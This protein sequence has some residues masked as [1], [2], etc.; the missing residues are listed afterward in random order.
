MSA[1]EERVA[2][3]ARTSLYSH[4]RRLRRAEANGRPPQ[5]GHL[6]PGLL[7][8]RSSRPWRESVA[9]VH[10]ILAPLLTAADTERAAD[11]ADRALGRLPITHRAALAAVARLPLD[12]EESAHALGRRLVRTGTNVPAVSAGL[13]LLIRLGR[14]DDIPVLTTIGLLYPCTV[15]AVQALDRLHPA[16]AALLR[17]TAHNGPPPARK[18]TAALAAPDDAAVHAALLSVRPGSRSV[19]PS[20]ARRI[21][22]AVGL[23]G[24]LHQHPVDP[25]L[26]AQAGRLLAR[27]TGPGEQH[28]EILGYPD[29][30]PALEAIVRR[31]AA[32]TPTIDHHAT[33]LSLALDLH[34]GP[35]V[36]LPW[37]PGQR[38]RLLA[39]LGA[40]LATPAWAAV[41]GRE[42]ADPVR[43]RRVAWLRRTAH[44]PFATTAPGPL[45]VE[46]TAGDPAGSGYVETR[47]LLDG[48]PVAPDLFGRGPG[49]PP[50][51]LLD[52]GTLRA[53]AEPRRV[54]LAE[55]SCT[56]GCCGALHV[57][58]AREGNEV[59]W[60]DWS[61]PA[62]PPGKE[63]GPPPERRF[64]A[65]AYDAEIARA[66]AD[67]TW[68]WPAR[69][70][71]RL[72][73]ARLRE[74][75]ELLTRWELEFGWAGTGHTDP[76]TTILYLD[77]RRRTGG[78]AEEATGP[79]LRFRWSL[80]DDGRPPA[81]RAAAALRRLAEGD[82]KRWSE[83][84]G[85]SRA[86]A[87]ALGFPWP[88][89]AG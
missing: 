61:R 56:E 60:R 3:T 48:R 11:T 10:D 2:L 31:A 78:E 84:T 75:P 68:E 82:P 65:A 17:I 46:V 7:R 49:E 74:R 79:R 4:A 20:T 66:E 9:A 44:V 86:D 26:V 73:A 43:R 45:R 85:G 1:P 28:P 70:T 6:P 29:A 55:A 52:D 54:R 89:R 23:A 87:E 88:E 50:D 76:D 16:K 21:A 64:D 35:G 22:E 77:H 71:A 58:V 80:P 57:T 14:P 30:V 36:L 83:V 24:R 59:V 67:R 5:G 33:L 25:A 81:E 13:G 38:E 18:L 42:P 34:S 15:P 39:A 19:P 53:T 47:I 27:M 62:S 63:A 8:T 40:L 37:Q 32:L 41:L 72:I 69:T 12:D 51:R